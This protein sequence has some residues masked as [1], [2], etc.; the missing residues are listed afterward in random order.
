MGFVF[1]FIQML[2]LLDLLRYKSIFLIEK[3]CIKK[4]YKKALL[5]K[6]MYMYNK[7]KIHKYNKYKNG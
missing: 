6:K 3:K 1:F 2:G 7:N 4:C 5:Y